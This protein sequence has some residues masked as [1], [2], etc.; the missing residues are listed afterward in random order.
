M[1][2]VP[3]IKNKL[4]IIGL[5]Y[6]RNIQIH[7]GDTAPQSSERFFSRT[8]YFERSGFVSFFS[9]TGYMLQSLLLNVSHRFK[10]V[11]NLGLSQ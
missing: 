7:K 4:N 9:R 6:L 2:L 5:Q 10:I 11:L 1:K 8:R 3:L